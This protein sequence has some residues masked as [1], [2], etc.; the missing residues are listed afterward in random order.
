VHASLLL[1]LLSIGCG[2]LEP[3]DTDKT[4]TPVED[5][6]P[7]EL[8]LGIDTVDFGDVAFGDLE[9]VS[10]PV[11]NA[12]SVA[13]VLTSITT[14]SPF[15]ASP[16]TL[17]LRGGESNVLNVFV[18]TT[19]YGTFAG[20]LTIVSD[21]GDIGTVTIPLTA[22]TISDV[23]GDGFDTV[24]AVG[25]TDCDDD[26][27]TVYP[28][29]PDEWYD[30]D[31]DNCD[32][33]NE[34]DRDGDGYD[35]E[36]DEHDV[37]AG[38][39]DCN[40]GDVTF[41]PGAADEPYDGRDTD[42]DDASDFDN[43]SDGYDSLAYGRGSDCDDF[44]ATVNREGDERFNGKDDDCDGAPD[45]D[46][47][48]ARA[49]YVYDYSGGT[50]ERTGYATAVGDLDGDGI[51]EVIVAAPYLGASNA[52]ASGRGGVAV[53]RG[54]D[55]LATG[56]DVDT[57]DNWFEGDGTGDLLGSFVTVLGDYDGDG[58]NELAVG[59]PGTSSG[60]GS[61][62]ILG[63]EDARTSGIDTGD[64]L[65][66]YT[67][68]TSAA[69]GRGI[70]TD[71]DLNADGYDEL[72]VMY[73]S[74]SA[75]AVAVE[76]GSAAPVSGSVSAMDATWSTDGTE[77]AFYRNAPVGGDLD[78]DGYPDLV[79][80]DG[81]SDAGATDGGALWVLWGQAAPYASAGSPIG[82][83][84]TTLVRGTSGSQYAA[85][86]TQLGEDW[87]GDEDDEL[88]IFGGDADGRKA[89]HVV[90]GGINRRAPFDPAV[91]AAARY[92]W[93]TLSSDA[94]TIRRAGDWDGD[95]VSD[96]LVFLEDKTGSFGKSEL[97]SSDKRSGTYDELDD[98]IG[99]LVG[100]VDLDTSESNGNVGYGTSPKGGDVDGD[101]D[102]DLA[103]GDPEWQTAK[104][105]AYVLL[106]QGATGD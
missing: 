19:D 52:S 71:I 12:G 48:A 2:G 95:G 45:N 77:I 76:Y 44:D 9:S 43:D 60:A 90:E 4:P 10:I 5:E 51:A 93:D 30:G 68:V 1:V 40:D 65:A 85:W 29:A 25:G 66:T 11:R 88:W 70:G 49:D 98:R 3:Y 103:L 87:D 14:A 75:N 106:N 28:G 101:G 69:F 16:A 38:M 97:F 89:L 27:A 82:S 92:T 104:G 83:A 20:T 94:E 55:L 23:D 41:N 86:S 24:D 61:V 33:A 58:V 50:F 53:F 46:A 100:G 26:N 79:L 21:S 36:T 78:G 31:D 7:A 96:M 105:K 34:Y 18:Q 42:C 47:P 32:G 72:V 63:G 67:G 81:K 8:I 84:A 99:S 35:V 22:H 74:S 91:D 62:Y 73:A 102:D 13:L 17:T 15:R 39:V 56:T 54:P 57:A 6:T 80:S 59:A 37:P 64:A